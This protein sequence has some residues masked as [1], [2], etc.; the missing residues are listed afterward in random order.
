MRLI[1][2]QTNQIFIPIC[3]SNSPINPKTD[4][5]VIFR[6]HD[7]I[8]SLSLDGWFVADVKKLAP[9]FVHKTFKLGAGQKE[10]DM[11][12]ELDNALKQWH[13]KEQLNLIGGYQDPK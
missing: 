8:Q 1:K 13:A 7:K 3:I 11:R 12:L 4:F 5:N 10:S 6:Q 2:T 9:K